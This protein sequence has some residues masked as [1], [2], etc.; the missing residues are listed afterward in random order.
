MVKML[1]TDMVP[2][3]R[4]KRE[5]MLC[6]LN[7]SEVDGVHQRRKTSLFIGPHSCAGRA[8]VRSPLPIGVC[9]VPMGQHSDNQS[10]HHFLFLGALDK[11]KLIQSQTSTPFVISADM[12]IPLSLVRL[13]TTPP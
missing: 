9:V 13:S 5:R 3:R 6:Y 7:G 8:T 11:A 10:L 1:W 2:E 4:I 12:S